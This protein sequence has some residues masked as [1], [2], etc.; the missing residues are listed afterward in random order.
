[1]A[2]KNIA[3][4]GEQ[5]QQALQGVVF[6]DEWEVFVGLTG[7]IVDAHLAAG[8]GRFCRR[9]RRGSGGRWCADRRA[10]LALHGGGGG[11]GVR[12][13]WVRCGF[14]RCHISHPRVFLRVDELL[15]RKGREDE[16]RGKGIAGDASPPLIPA[17]VSSTPP[18]SADFSHLPPCAS[19]QIEH[20]YCTPGACA[21][22]YINVIL[23]I[24]DENC[25]PAS[26]MSDARATAVL[27][28]RL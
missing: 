2:I 5:M 10:S 23:I 3:I 21:A 13:R 25:I 1:M 24:F 26:A 11:G 12:R 22:T 19:G 7:E 18:Y 15:K 14:H 20:C 4:S 17:G 27:V 8:F 28:R 16:M 9:C 6:G